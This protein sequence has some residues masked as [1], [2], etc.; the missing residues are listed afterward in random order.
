[1]IIICVKD[2]HSLPQWIGEQIYYS[3]VA[4]RIQNNPWASRD[5]TTDVPVGTDAAKTASRI[6]IENKRP[7]NPTK[8]RPSSGQ[9]LPPVPPSNQRLPFNQQGK[10]QRYEYI[11]PSNDEETS[12]QDQ[13][14]SSFS[15]L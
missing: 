13:I 8:E 3:P 11:E 14:S 12:W 2:A 15:C 9:H 6:E 7:N 10:Q 4:Y 1:M 5:I